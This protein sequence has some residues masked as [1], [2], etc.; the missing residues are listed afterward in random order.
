MVN[1]TAESQTA[2]DT[3]P[4]S[5]KNSCVILD[6]I[7]AK[8]RKRVADAKA[9]LPPRELW[10]LAETLPPQAPAFEEALGTQG[11]SF[12]CEVK[13][14]SPSRGLIDRNA[15]FPHLAIAKEYES[16]GAA[17]ISVLTEPDYFL[18]SNTYL[19]EIA[20]AV[21]IP[22]LRKDFIIDEYQLYEAKALG[23]SAALLICALLDKNSLADFCAR[24]KSL[25]LSVLVEV[26]NKSEL[27]TALRA[28][29]RIIGINNRDLATFKVDIAVTEQLRPLIPGEHIV[30]SESGIHTQDEVK[31]MAA[32]AVNALLVG[33]SIMKAPDKRAFLKELRG[34]F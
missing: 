28:R 30:V 12:I 7:A 31:R 14:A 21:K 25:S 34:Q 9:A 2:L 1:P 23:A 6:E 11:I 15:V 24:A 13:R 22:V 17:A 32:C 16:A 19:K 18:G 10:R 20:A 29:P 5:I 8:T 3:P 26:H 4:L 27:E 33:E